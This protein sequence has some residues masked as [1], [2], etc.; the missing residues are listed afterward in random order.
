[1]CIVTIKSHLFNSGII[2]EVSMVMKGWNAG[3]Q[4][5]YPN[6]STP[7]IPQSVN[8]CLKNHLHN[9]CILKGMQAY[10]WFKDRVKPFQISFE[11]LYKELAKCLMHSRATQIFVTVR[12]RR[13]YLWLLFFV[14]NHYCWWPCFVC[15][16]C[17]YLNNRNI[18]KSLSTWKRFGN[19]VWFYSK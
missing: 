15:E 11:D 18:K 10:F 4:V 13:L 1:M 8:Q 17:K 12:L 5:C 16:F 2:L 6:T 14:I 9:N 3:A 7:I 19:C